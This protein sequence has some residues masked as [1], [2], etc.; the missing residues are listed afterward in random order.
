MESNGD[1]A[2]F[3]QIMNIVKKWSK[4]TNWY[5]SSYYTHFRIKIFSNNKKANYKHPN[6]I[7]K[8]SI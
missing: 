7:F 3:E 4:H 6:I 1:Y 8:Q 2:E 5:F